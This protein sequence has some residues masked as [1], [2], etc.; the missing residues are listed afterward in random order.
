MAFEK[1]GSPKFDLQST[2]F[3][4]QVIFKAPNCE[5]TEYSGGPFRN[6]INRRFFKTG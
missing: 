2:I 4:S 1:W 3:S 5:A 6:H